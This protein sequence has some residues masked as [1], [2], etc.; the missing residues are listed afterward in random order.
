[1]LKYP[2]AAARSGLRVAATTIL[3]Y[4]ATAPAATFSVNSDSDT[5]DNMPG[6][7]TCFTGL[8]IVEVGAECTLRAA[9]EEANALAGADTIEFAATIPLSGGFVEIDP[10]TALPIIVDTVVIDGY[11]APGYDTLDPWATPVVSISGDTPG[12]Q[13]QAGLNFL[14]GS[15]NSVVRGLA[16]YE[17]S[18]AGVVLN[19]A[20]SQTVEGNHLGLR[21]GAFYL[22]NDHGVLL[23]DA[24]GS[25]VGKTCDDSTCSG[26]GNL[27]VASA[28]DG[29]WVSA[30]GVQ[31]HGNRIGTTPDGTSISPPLGA[32]GNA[33]FGVYVEEDDVRLGTGARGSG[34]LISGN[35]LGGV[36]L[37]GSDGELR[38]NWIGTD[39]TGT[40]DLGNLGS[41][42]E[43]GGLG[44]KVMAGNVISGNSEN[45]VLVTGED[46]VVEN[47]TIGLT[48]D[49][50]SP[51]GNSTSG[52]RIQA[53][54]TTVESNTIGAN[55]LDG[56]RIESM[57]NTI[58]ANFVGTNA[59]NDDVG[60]GLNGIRDSGGLNDI[61]QAELGNVIG[62]NNIGIQIVGGAQS[63]QIRGNYI[64]TDSTG[65]DIGNGV[66][67]IELNDGD[68]IGIGGLDAM[69]TGS[70]NVIGNT[71]GPGIAITGLSSFIDIRGNYIGTDPEGRDLGNDGSG[72]LCS[73]PSSFF[74][75]DAVAPASETID[76]GNEIAFNSGDGVVMLGGSSS[77]TIRGNLIH[78]NGG[79]A[80]DLGSDGPTPNDFGDDDTGANDLQN[81]PEFDALNTQWNEQTGELEVRYRVT[82]NVQDSD[83]PLMI[84]FYLRN[85]ATGGTDRYLGADTYDA[86]DAVLFRATSFAPLGGGPLNGYLV[87]TATTDTGR[88]SELSD[89]VMVPEPSATRLAAVAIGAVSS[90]AALR[91]RAL[92]H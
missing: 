91:R 34:N 9:I 88:T 47:A 18:F 84:D 1:M 19:G 60:N 51:L 78:D 75:A 24:N 61:G 87:A 58:V 76:S 49:S 38:G 77:A 57:S 80:I 83:Y 28:S 67:G 54:G 46:A 71:G 25:I 89:P 32:S 50:A 16:I 4:A 14:A 2:L 63:T 35:G 21:G 8:F 90:L 42:V 7:G 39:V 81:F 20:G 40:V 45:G 22:G 43:L 86:G 66:V 3:L 31:I 52:I 12:G 26:K 33:E 29:I 15:E 17:F 59:A 68:V 30:D 27:I 70:A 65:A 85:A 23:T 64:G 62:F 74:G 92:R 48:A 69:N 72:I 6:D 10:Q 82:S 37:I 55:A 53:D 73:C 44:N 5:G 36:Q 11:T 79:E 56:I 13:I 41:G